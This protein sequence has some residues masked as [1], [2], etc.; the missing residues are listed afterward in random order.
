MTTG[1]TKDPKSEGKEAVEPHVEV[2]GA[3]SAPKFPP[4]DLEFTAY[5]GG[6]TSDEVVDIVKDQGSPKAPEWEDRNAL[7]PDRETEPAVTVHLR[8]R[9]ARLA[10]PRLFEVSDERLL[11]RFG[12]AQPRSAV[13][14]S[15]DS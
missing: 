7:L 10:N 14:N 4:G 2:P 6:V 3:A 11:H 8:A 5:G 12:A 15:A 9:I 1:A 13:A